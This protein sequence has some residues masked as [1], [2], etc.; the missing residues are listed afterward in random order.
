MPIRRL[1]L[2]ALLL[3]ASLSPAQAQEALPI[4]SQWGG[5]FT[6]TDQNG[7]PISLSD[8]KGKVV[9]LTFGYTH[10]PDICPNT[11]LILK[12]VIKKLGDK[13]EQAQVVFI[14]LD[15]ARDYPERLKT[16]VEFF[17][18]A[19]VAL[20]GSEAEIAAVASRYGMRYEKEFFDSELTYGIAHTT[21]I[22]LIDQQ[23]RIRAFY[24]LSAPPSRIASGVEQLLQSTE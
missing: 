7:L 22:Y 19:F 20:T 15:P 13:A 21:I 11:L 17:N 18:P 10:C 5:D 9:L 6:L 23:S 24:R 1:L 16:F 14:T 2:S 8:L 3:L 4:H 12:S